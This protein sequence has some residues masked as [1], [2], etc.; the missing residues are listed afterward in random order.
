MYFRIAYA[1]NKPTDKYFTNIIEL[2][3]IWQ[4]KLSKQQNKIDKD[5]RRII[6]KEEKYN[7]KSK[8]MKKKAGSVRP[9]RKL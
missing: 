7:K 5:N 1:N 2:Y 4:N 9:K 3:K 8:K 6:Q